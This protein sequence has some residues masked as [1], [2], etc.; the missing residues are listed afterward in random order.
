MSDVNLRPKASMKMLFRA[1]RLDKIT[2]GLV[3][4][5]EG[6][7]PSTQPGVAGMLI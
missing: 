2:E 3:V 7:G 1:V 5:G 6:R 4:L